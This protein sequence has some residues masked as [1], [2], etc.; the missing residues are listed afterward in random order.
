V[1]TVVGVG[2]AGL[3][4]RP[5][6]YDRYEQRTVQVFRQPEQKRADELADRLNGIS[7]DPAGE[8]GD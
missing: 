8:K 2:H 3:T 4:Q 5:A 7:K 1:S 6:V